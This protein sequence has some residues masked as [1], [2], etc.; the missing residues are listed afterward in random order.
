MGV[1]LLENQEG[2]TEITFA[3][4][5]I[6]SK[7]RRRDLVAFDWW[8]KNGD[9]QL[10]EIGGNPNLLWTPESDSMVVIDH[11]MAFDGGVRGGSANLHSGLSGLSA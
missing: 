4:R 9:R 10:T 3:N 11:N 1:W 8:I 6:V 2:S 7:T 5:S